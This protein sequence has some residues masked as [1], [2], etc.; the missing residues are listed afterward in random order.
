MKAKYT[1][2]I[3]IDPKAGL[4]AHEIADTLNDVE[5]RIVISYLE[6]YKQ[7]V[8]TFLMLHQQNSEMKKQ[9]AKK[10]E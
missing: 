2:E 8:L 6:E 1:L 7:R 10:A 5:A 9:E 3:Y 4:V